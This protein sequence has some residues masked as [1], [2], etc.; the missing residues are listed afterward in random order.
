[1]ATAPLTAERPS[2]VQFKRI[3]L[4]TDFSPASRLALHYTIAF[5][6]RYGSEVLALHALRPEP[7][8]PIPLDPLPRELN[9]EQPHAPEEM[10]AIDEEFD[11]NRIQHRNETIFGKPS[12]AITNAI[13]RER[14]DLVVL[15]THG[16]AAPG[17]LAFGSVAEQVLRMVSCPV[18]TLGPRVSPPMM[19]KIEFK[20]I[21]FA[22]DF[23]PSCKRACELALS[24]AEEHGSELLLLHLLPPMVL[25]QGATAYSPGDY[26]YDDVAAWTD[27]APAKSLS[28]LKELIPPS[29]KLKN[30]PQFLVETSF[31]PDAIVDAAEMR[32]ADLIVMG[33]NRT[34]SPRLTAHLPWAVVWEVLRR[35]R[36]PVLTVG[37]GQASVR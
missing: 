20:S 21:V 6:R 4:A 22:T 31:L 15:G 26:A 32:G 25:A 28:R 10:S 14:P 2:A 11:C 1:M 9:R 37:V 30:K 13:A 36:V 33:A 17:K 3:L 24:L 12:S 7:R 5:A 27:A 16:R 34:R 23:G 29:V 19:A 35:A 18:L 8:E